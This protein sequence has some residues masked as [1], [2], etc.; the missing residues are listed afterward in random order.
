MDFQAWERWL[1]SFWEGVFQRKSNRPLQPVEIAR[2]LVREMTLQRRVS[3]SRIYAPNVFTVSLGK[4]DYEK[5]A[6][7]QGPFSREL[8]EYLRSKAAEKGFT[9]I[10]RPQV[11]FIEEPS[12]GIGE[13]RVKS[14]F[15][16]PEGT[17]YCFSASP[18]EERDAL[19]T[20]EPLTGRA[21][22]PE[23]H[24]I[25]HTM[26]FNKKELQEKG[27]FFL[28]VVRGP[29]QGKAFPLAGERQ[30]MIGRKNSNQIVLSD[31]NTSREHAL[32]EWRDGNL[33]LT[34]L[35][36]RNGTLVNGT[37]IQQQRLKVG[38]KIQ[39]GEN[40]LQVEGG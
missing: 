12:L 20:E 14:A 37:P 29:D 1:T 4:A 24:Q 36:S 38:D 16:S 10:G 21:Q 18:G 13:I 40:V 6:P 31:L 30:Y 27:K 32:I 17:E 35:Q 34:D 8:E 22:G 3:V 7:L 33:F 9:L 28:R 39:I 19:E 2:V 23:V 15:A 5:C 11:S 26:V 25:D